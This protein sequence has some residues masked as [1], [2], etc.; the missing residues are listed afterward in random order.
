MT[1]VPPS[2]SSESRHDDFK[3]E[4]MSSS[5]VSSSSSLALP[6]EST[7]SSNQETK[8]KKKEM[9]KK[10]KSNKREAT[11]A[12]ISLSTS[13]VRTPS[14]SPQ[15]VKFPCKLCKGDHLLR[16]CPYVP[17]ILEVWSHDLAHPSSSSKAHVNV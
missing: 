5:S 6:G 13:Q 9:K 12:T 2:P 8:N 16:D 17:M 10:K 7:T 1:L 4:P 15:K 11:C 14:T 3:V